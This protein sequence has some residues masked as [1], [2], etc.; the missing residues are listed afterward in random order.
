MGQWIDDNKSVYIRQNL[1]Y[2]LIHY[3]NLGVIE[4]DK[5]RKNLKI[6]KNQPVRIE[7]EII[8]KIMKL[9]TKE[10]TAWHYKID[11]LPFEV[12]LCFLAHKL[13]GKVHEYGHVYYDKKTSNKTK[14]DRK[15]WFYFYQN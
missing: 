14:T 9:F 4:A 1:P 15:Y 2:N 3:N 6:Q 10:S 8:P 11:G 12:D 13:I 7:R 5:F